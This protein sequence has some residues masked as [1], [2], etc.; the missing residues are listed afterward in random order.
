MAEYKD[1]PGSATKSAQSRKA[2][3]TQGVA[4]ESNDRNNYNTAQDRAA[5]DRAGAPLGPPTQTI[6]TASEQLTCFGRRVERLMS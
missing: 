5:Q 2:T 6:R 3:Q 4:V 1:D